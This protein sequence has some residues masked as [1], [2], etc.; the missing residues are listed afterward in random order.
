[1]HH[2]PPPPLYSSLYGR[3][4]KMGIF[5]T[6][7]VQ[8]GVIASKAVKQVSIVRRLERLLDNGTVRA[9]A[10]YENAV[11]GLLQEAVDSGCIALISDG[12]KVSFHHQLLMVTVA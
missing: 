12:T 7:K 5:L 10:W 4:I 1:M 3:L 8:T 9:R 11:V 2:I 6:K